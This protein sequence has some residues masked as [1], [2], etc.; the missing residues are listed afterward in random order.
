[1]ALFNPWIRSEESLSAA[2]IRGYYAVRIF[3]ADF[4]HN[5]VRG[6]IHVVGAIRSFLTNFGAFARAHS[7]AEVP[8]WQVAMMESLESF[9]GPVMILLS[10]RDLT[11]REFSARLHRNRRRRC[12]RH[13]NVIIRELPGADHTFSTGAL[14]SEVQRFTLEWLESHVIAGR[15]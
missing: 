1:M 12:S 9:A 11:A 14:K 2:H 13:R 8:G 7:A 6:R 3:E 10:G 5:L 15:P 4:W